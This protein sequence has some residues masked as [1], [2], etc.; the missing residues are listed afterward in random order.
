[1][2][3]GRAVGLHWHIIMMALA[4]LF[5]ASG[6]DGLKERGNFGALQIYLG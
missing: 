6:L 4:W 1:M 3:F 2:F 5:S